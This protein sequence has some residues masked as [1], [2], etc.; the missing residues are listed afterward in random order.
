MRCLWPL[1]RLNVGRNTQPSR[2]HWQVPPTPATVSSDGCCRR[3]LAWHG[4]A[5]HSHCSLQL[6]L[7]VPEV[8]NMKYGTDAEVTHTGSSKF[9]L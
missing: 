2:A 4:W 1:V 3:P 7:A 8:P 6:G 9:L 5:L